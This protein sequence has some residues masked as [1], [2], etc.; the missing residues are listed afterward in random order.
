VGAAFLISLQIFE[1]KPTLVKNYCVWVTYNSRS[2]THNCAK[3]YRDTSR[4]GA[5]AQMYM[6]FASRHRVRFRSLHIRDVAAIPASKCKR[7]AVT[8]FHVDNFLTSEFLH[9][10]Y[11]FHRRTRSSSLF[12]TAF[13]V[14]LLVK[15]AADFW[16][17]APALSIKILDE[18]LRIEL[19]KI[20][21]K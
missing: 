14:L 20:T 10:E 1:E 9:S 6:D 15:S 8:Q 11:F 3:E 13:I 16:L 5:V 12:L 19:N 17:L 2:G 18:G 21:R 4:C 7:L